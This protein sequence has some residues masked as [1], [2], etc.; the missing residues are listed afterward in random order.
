VLLRRPAWQENA[1]C[2]GRGSATWFPGRH[3][4][5]NVA[6][7]VCRGCA[8]RVDCL[9]YALAHDDMPGVWGGTVPRQRDTARRHGVDAATLL[10]KL[11]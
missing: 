2:A 1:A 11:G 9:E 6:R 8:A 10:A 7:A 5:V 3:D 4:D